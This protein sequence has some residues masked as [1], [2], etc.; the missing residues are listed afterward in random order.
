MVGGLVL[1]YWIRVDTPFWRTA[2]FMAVF[3]LGL[4]FIMQP[5]TLAVQNAMAPSEIGVA[6]SSATFFRQM[7]ATAG[8]AIFLSILFSTV[9]DKISHAFRTAG[10]GL[11]QALAD[12]SITGDPKNQQ[13]LGV[14]HG[15]G[16]SGSALNDTS[17]LSKVTPVLAR[18]FK[19]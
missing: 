1:M 3:G 6:T 10:P 5:I 8:T 17:F 19:V 2:I 14:L 15:S 13:I 12:K 9:G 4:G 7:G 18:P 16:V 11:Q